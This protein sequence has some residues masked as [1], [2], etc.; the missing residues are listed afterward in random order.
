MRCSGLR[1]GI[2]IER[3]ELEGIVKLADSLK[4]EGKHG[5]VKL[6]NE[7]ENKTYSVR[8]PLTQM[9]DV[10]QPYFE[11]YVIITGY[12]IGKKLYLEDIDISESQQE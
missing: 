9:Q 2:A 6:L 3:I 10:V 11:E 4:I 5:I 12:R 1:R 7:K 8:V